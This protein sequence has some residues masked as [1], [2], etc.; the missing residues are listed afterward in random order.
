LQLNQKQ[1][2]IRAC[3]FASGKA[4]GTS[5]LRPWMKQKCTPLRPTDSSFLTKLVALNLGLEQINQKKVNQRHLNQ[6]KTETIGS[7][8]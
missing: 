2:L 3:I 7:S 1:K 8:A 5:S 4:F 6:T